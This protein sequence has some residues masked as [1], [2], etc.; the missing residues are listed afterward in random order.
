MIE[1]YFYEKRK[2][3]T[4]FFLVLVFF[5]EAPSSLLLSDILPIW[6]VSSVWVNILPFWA[7]LQFVSHFYGVFY[8]LLGR[9]T[10]D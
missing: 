1:S 6:Y 4:E 8:L 2:Y 5:S 9:M 10:Y 7:F 3:S